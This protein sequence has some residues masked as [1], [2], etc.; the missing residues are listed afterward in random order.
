M[1]MYCYPN[2]HCHKNDMTLLFK[3]NMVEGGGTSTNVINNG[4]KGMWIGGDK[5]HFFT[6]QDFHDSSITKG[7]AALCPPN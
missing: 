4:E 7:M 3:H 5:K 1:E 2:K 6:S